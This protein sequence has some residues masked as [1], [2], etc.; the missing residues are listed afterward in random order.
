MHPTLYTNVTRQI[1]RPSSSDLQTADTA[2]AILSAV[3]RDLFRNDITWGKVCILITHCAFVCNL[4]DLMQIQRQIY[5][6]FCY[7]FTNTH[8]L[9]WSTLFV[10]VM[11]AI[12]LCKCIKSRSTM[13][14]ITYKSNNLC[15]HSRLRDVNECA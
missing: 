9:I 10:I 6:W 11:N 3:A 12:A 4:L 15:K 1:T 5:E 13:L 2:P 8:E 7:N 14:H